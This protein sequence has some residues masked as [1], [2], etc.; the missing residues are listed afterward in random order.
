MGK[1]RRW[2]GRMFSKLKVGEVVYVEPICNALRELEGGILSNVKEYKVVKVAR[3]Y[4]YIELGYHKL[5]CYISDGLENQGE[6]SP[7]YKAHLSLQ[8]I[9]DE[10]E[11]KEIAL[12]LKWYN[13]PGLDIGQWRRIKG[14]V[15]EVG[16]V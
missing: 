14:I 10:I 8:T 9:K 7:D 5:K 3:K 6:Y 4:F 2:R 16:K 1:P 11:V 15:G 13:A 12:A